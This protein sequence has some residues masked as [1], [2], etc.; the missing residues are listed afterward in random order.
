VALRRARCISNLAC[1]TILAT[2]G[3]R[4]IQMACRSC[5]LG[6]VYH[7]LQKREQLRG[8]KKQISQNAERNRVGQQ[9]LL[10]I[11]LGFIVVGIAVAVAI[12]IFTDSALDSNR[13][14]VANDLVNLAARAQQYYRRPTSLDGGGNSFEGLTADAEGLAKLTEKPSNANGVYSIKTA[15]TAT[16]LVLEGVGTET[17]DGTTKV[18]VEIHVSNTKADSVVII[19]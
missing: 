5:L 19:H 6:L 17:V 2:F 8:P 13:E 14:A 18:T 10:I 16:G 1:W 11:L 15:G 12:T 9:Q 7:L 3:C 4:Q